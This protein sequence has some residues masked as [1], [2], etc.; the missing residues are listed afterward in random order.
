[1]SLSRKYCY[2]DDE[3]LLFVVGNNRWIFSK[4]DVS[5]RGYLSAPVKVTK[6]F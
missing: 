5:D 6:R 1:M 3:I 4:L 2:E